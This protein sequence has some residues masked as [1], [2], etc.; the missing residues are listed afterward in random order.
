MT[1]EVWWTVA[2]IVWAVAA[3]VWMGVSAVA[4]HRARRAARRFDAH[5]ADVLLIVRTRHP[6]ARRGPPEDQ[7]DW[8]L[9]AAGYRQDGNGVWHTPDCGCGD[10]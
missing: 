9:Y 6:S 2:L 3:L 8:P 5:V 1:V 7:P 10:L 4:D